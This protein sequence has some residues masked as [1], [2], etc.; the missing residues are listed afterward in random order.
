M[1]QTQPDDCSVCFGQ[2][3]SHG[4]RNRQFGLDFYYCPFCHLFLYV[5][6]VPNHLC[7]GHKRI[8]NPNKT[9]IFLSCDGNCRGCYMP[10][11]YGIYCRYMQYA[12]WFYC[13]ID[14]LCDY[15]LFRIIRIQ[16]NAHCNCLIYNILWINDNIKKRSCQIGIKDWYEPGLCGNVTEVIALFDRPDFGPTNYFNKPESFPPPKQ[17][18]PAGFDW[19][20]WLGPTAFR[21]FNSTYAPKIWRR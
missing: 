6:Y 7:F 19:D 13:S 3:C 5:C 18:I 8:G 16:D 1:D 17:L 12:A 2:Y 14:M 11:I 4:Y 20:L 10:D 9:S 21:P 15:F